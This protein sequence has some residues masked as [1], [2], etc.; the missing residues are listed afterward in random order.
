MTRRTTFLWLAATL[1]LGATALAQCPRPAPGPT[2]TS[3]SIA[4]V[5]GTVQAGAP[6]LVKA[7]LVNRSGQTVPLWSENTMDQAGWR[8]GVEVHDADGKLPIETKFGS[9]HGGHAF[10]TMMDPLDIDSRYIT[11]SGGC[12]KFDTGASITDVV[13]VGKMYVLDEPGT[14]TI[15]LESRDPVSMAEVKSNPVTVTVLSAPASPSAQATEKAPP[16]APFSLD[17]SAYPTT[18]KQGLPVDVLVIT[19]NV[20]NHRIVLRRQARSHDAGMLGSVF[21]VD[22]RD[23]QGNTPPDMELGRAANHLADTSPDPASMAAARAA[24]TVVS[25]KPGQDWRNGVSVSDLCDLSKPGQYTI[26][27]R[28]WDD[29]TKTWVKSN[30]ITVTVTP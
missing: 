24:G 14:Y 7:T 21:R 15:V 23:T 17:L 26:Q 1:P 2:A 12:V 25:L 3:L 5:K 11:A 30:A 6:V 27:V 9:Y 28:R 20:S 8:Y 18:I 13:D 16:S 22:V 19:K 10:V 4:A 29:E